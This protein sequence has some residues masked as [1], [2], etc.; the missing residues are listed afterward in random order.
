MKKSIEECE[1]KDLNEILNTYRK[2]VVT[3]VQCITPAA[4]SISNFILVYKDGCNILS[5]FDFEYQ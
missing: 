5:M 3:S 4:M 1:F 2:S